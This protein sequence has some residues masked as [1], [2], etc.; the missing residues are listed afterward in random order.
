MKKNNRVEKKDGINRNSIGNIHQE[1]TLIHQKLDNLNQAVSQL[2]EIKLLLERKKGRRKGILSLGREREMPQP[3]QVP[4]ADP[5][6]ALLKNLPQS[7][8]MDMTAILK[9]MNDPLIK[10]LIQSLKK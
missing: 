1:L 10:G 4:H 9:I 3:K 6:S 7:P 5:F 2:E 8:N